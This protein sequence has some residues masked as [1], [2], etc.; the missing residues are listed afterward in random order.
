MNPN[1]QL[2]EDIAEIHQSRIGNKEFQH[3]YRN[4]QFTRNIRDGNHYFNGPKKISPPERH[5]PSSLLQCQRKSFY[6]QLN[7]PEE[8]GDPNGIFWF[9]SRFEEDVILPFLQDV[10]TGE[11]TYVCN[12]LWVDFTVDTEIGEL[13][14][15]GATDPVIVD[16]D[17]EP[18]LL[19]EI[20]T[21]QTV[22]SL[23]EPNRHHK[24][25][26]HAYI[27]G[28]NEKYERDIRSAVI[29]Y[30]SRT[31]LKIKLFQIEFDDRFWNDVVVEW[32]K[33]HTEYRVDTELPPA[34]PEYDW[35]CG[36]CS[37]KERC[38]KGECRHSDIGPTGLL[39][40]FS[41][42]PKEKLIE[43][44]EAHQDAKLTP[45]LAWE[46][47]ELVEEHDVY[48]W[49]CSRC[50]ARHDWQSVNPV[51]SDTELPSC[52]SCAGPGPPGWLSGPETEIQEQLEEDNGN[53]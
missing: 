13:Q 38:G 20:K 17:A 19:F 24:A 43:Y 47:T 10:V 36:F 21:K 53:A 37:Y 33:T 16:D 8:T 41:D 52:P 22:S 30:G 49:H 29:L 28:L 39:P 51:E 4:Q 40:G 12:S 31:S 45:I 9:G 3:W 27:Q 50:E 25:Q 6:N 15:K 2:S 42:Y 46:F 44:L 1:V 14:I 5:S 11:D 23:S 32:A 26:I 18:L 7:A 35:E 34:A 48:D